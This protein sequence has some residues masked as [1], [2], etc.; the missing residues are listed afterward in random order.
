MKGRFLG[1]LEDNWCISQVYLQSVYII[2]NYARRSTP[3]DWNVRKYPCHGK[4]CSH[5]SLL[6]HP[7]KGPGREVG[8][9]Q[10]KGSNKKARQCIYD[11]ELFKYHRGRAEGCKEGHMLTSDIL[12]IV[13]EEVRET[14]IEAP[15]YIIHKKYIKIFSAFPSTSK[16]PFTKISNMSQ[17]LLNQELEVMYVLLIA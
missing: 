7:L 16:G 17:S 2:Y 8:Q 12:C 4:C 6:F 15:A 9:H 11:R 13:Y 10:R 14:I 1:F 3:R 5:I